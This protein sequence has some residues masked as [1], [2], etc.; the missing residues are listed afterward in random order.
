MAF[1]SGEEGWTTPMAHTRVN[2]SKDCSMV[3]GS[4]LSKKVEM[5][6]RVVGNMARSRVMASGILP[7]GP[8]GRVHMTKMIG[9]GRGF[10]PR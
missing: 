7:M 4:T 1:L 10:R 9:M 5:C 6:M 8:H 3:G 2:G